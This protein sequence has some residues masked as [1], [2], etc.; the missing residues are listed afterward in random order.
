MARSYAS[1]ENKA[2]AAKKYMKK[3]GME[4]DQ[5][6]WTAASAAYAERIDK[7]RLTPTRPAAYGKTF[8]S[9]SGRTQRMRLPANK[10]SGRCE[11]LFFPV[12]ENCF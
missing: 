6:A 12:N 10:N 9:P 8:A 7:P 2:D 4:I 11:E 5:I 1:N 3:V